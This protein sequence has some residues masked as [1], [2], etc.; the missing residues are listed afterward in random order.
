MRAAS[1][2]TVILDHP[3]SSSGEG[4]TDEAVG[5]ESFSEPLRKLEQVVRE[6][7]SEFFF[8]SEQ[9]HGLISD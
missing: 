5:A 6:R 1:H 4:I 9:R 2:H 3:E 7:E 8:L